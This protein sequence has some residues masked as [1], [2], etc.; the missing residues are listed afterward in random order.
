MHTF[1]I[2]VN[3][4]QGNTADA[5]DKAVDKH[6][7]KWFENFVSND[8]NMLKP[9]QENNETFHIFIFWDFGCE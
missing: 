8:T 5:I 2:F 4:L 9:Y 3:Y 7:A 6:F 1:R